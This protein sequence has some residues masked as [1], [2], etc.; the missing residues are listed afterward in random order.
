MDVCCHY[1]T[2]AIH[3]IAF[4]FQMF[5]CLFDKHKFRHWKPHKIR[6]HSR[7]WMHVTIDRCKEIAIDINRIDLHATKH[8][9]W[10]YY[11]H[12][13]VLIRIVRILLVN[14]N[15]IGSRLSHSRHNY[16]CVFAM[17]TSLDD[18]VRLHSLH[19]HRLCE[20]RHH[21]WSH[22]YYHYYLCDSPTRRHIH[23]IS[24]SIN[25]LDLK[26]KSTNRERQRENKTTKSRH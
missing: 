22:R 11:W 19:S 26:K 7:K 2:I 3:F 14:L 6:A 1:R 15:H 12:S 25:Q 10:T 17:Q 24:L 23:S 9:K 8:F 5:V 18:G 20:M 21:C 13:I 4:G 16:G